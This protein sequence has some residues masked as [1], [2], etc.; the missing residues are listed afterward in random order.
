M[1][2]HGNCIALR[3]KLCWKSDTNFSRANNIYTHSNILAKPFEQLYQTRTFG[4]SEE[5][6]I[7]L[8]TII[9]DYDLG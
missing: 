1:S 2:V 7:V 4:F 9:F 8:S 6:G 3:T 5:G